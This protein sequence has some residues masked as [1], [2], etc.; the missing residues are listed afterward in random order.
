MSKQDVMLALHNF[1]KLKTLAYN[2]KIRPSLKFQVIPYAQFSSNRLSLKQ[3]QDL[4][5]HHDV[6]IFQ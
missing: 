3:K 2:A 4:Y 1:S 5:M 6:K